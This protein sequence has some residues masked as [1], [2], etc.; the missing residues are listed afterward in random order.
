[1]HDEEIKALAADL[2]TARA[3]TKRILYTPEIIQR[4]VQLFRRSGEAPSVFARR[5]GVSASALTRWVADAKGAAEFIPV[6]AANER[7]AS[8]A[9]PAATGAPEV[10]EAACAAPTP[11]PRGATV[12]VRETVVSIPADVDLGR[13]REIM[14]ALR[15]GAP[16]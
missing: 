6:F 15:G 7:S 5:L 8:E 14:A 1:M 4:A 13:V 3:G 16:C 12:V 10:S 11:R 9:P 2:A